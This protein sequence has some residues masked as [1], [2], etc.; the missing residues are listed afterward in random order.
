MYMIGQTTFQVDEQHKFAKQLGTC[1]HTRVIGLL[2]LQDQ[3]I[4]L[5]WHRCQLPRLPAVVLM[6]QLAGNCHPLAESALQAA[7]PLMSWWLTERLFLLADGPVLASPCM[8]HCC[9]H[10]RFDSKRLLSGSSCKLHS[11]AGQLDHH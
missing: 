2:D 5:F 11:S 4:Y 6:L 1:R 7:A 8:T 10:T 3:A 9:S